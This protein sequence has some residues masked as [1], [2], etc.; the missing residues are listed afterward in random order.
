MDTKPTSLHWPVAFSAHQTQLPAAPTPI[1]WTVVTNKK[2]GMFV[3]AAAGA[4]SSSKPSNPWPAATVAHPSNR[5]RRLMT[6]KLLS[7]SHIAVPVAGRHPAGEGY[8]PPTATV[9]AAFD[10]QTAQIAL[11]KTTVPIL[12]RAIEANAAV[13]TRPSSRFE[14]ERSGRAPALNPP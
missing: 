5:L 13:I 12:Y 9:S 7:P 8:L 3:L 14:T 6:S 4:W 2:S 10:R 1:A 11:Y